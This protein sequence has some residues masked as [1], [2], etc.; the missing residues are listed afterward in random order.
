MTFS[1]KIKNIWDYDKWYILG[2][3]AAAVAIFFFIKDVFFK[4][5][6]DY[7]VVY[8]APGYLSEEGLETFESV[9]SSYADDLNK[10]GKSNADVINI[11]FPSAEELNPQI[12]KEKNTL[13]MAEL[14]MQENCIFII[15]EDRLLELYENNTDAF[16]DLSELSDKIESGTYYIPIKDTGL[17]GRIPGLDENLVLALRKP[18]VAKYNDIY[19]NCRN[20][21]SR[22]LK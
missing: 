16:T 13:L 10:N 2:G 8:A 18:Y 17:S 1:Q 6:Y 5:K 19:N 11:E 12:D 22:I 9:L 15:A 4:E 20:Y 7:T 3:I 21:I 14:A